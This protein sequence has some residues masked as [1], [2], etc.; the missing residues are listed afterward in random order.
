MFPLEI[1]DEKAIDLISYIISKN[2]SV[3]I[4]VSY[5]SWEDTV[6]TLINSIS[7]LPLSSYNIIIESVSLDM[8]V[9]QPWDKVLS[10]DLQK[11]WVINKTEAWTANVSFS[12]WSIADCY[13]NTLVKFPEGITGIDL[14]VD[15]PVMAVP[16]EEPA[17]DPNYIPPMPDWI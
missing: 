10:L 15:E 4:T 1:W 9:L 7:E 2:P 16:F 17:E 11:F 8:T 13:W 3:K 14:G 12:D 6:T 5:V